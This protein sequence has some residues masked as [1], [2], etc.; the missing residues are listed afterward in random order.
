MRLLQPFVDANSVSVVIAFAPG[1]I[2]DLTHQRLSNCT[3]SG[4]GDGRTL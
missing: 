1:S 4:D 3:V 2:F